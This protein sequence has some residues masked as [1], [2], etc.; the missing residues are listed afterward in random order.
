MPP[1]PLVAGFFLLA[2]MALIG[3]ALALRRSV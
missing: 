1:M 3:Y 2:G